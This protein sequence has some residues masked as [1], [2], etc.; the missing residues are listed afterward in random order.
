M[1]SR[2]DELLLGEEL[3]SQNGKFTAKIDQDGHFRVYYLNNYLWEIDDSNI[4]RV[5][6]RKNGDLVVYDL[7]N[8]VF[9]KSGTANKGDRLVLDNDAGLRVYDSNANQL[10]SRGIIKSKNFYVNNDQIFSNLRL[11]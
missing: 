8:N 6:M 2:G 9:L 4:G 3:T 10:W 7:E 5:E 1:L 11:G